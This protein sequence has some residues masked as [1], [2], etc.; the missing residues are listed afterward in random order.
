MEWYEWTAWGLA[1]TTGLYSA[2]RWAIEDRHRK[3]TRPKWEIRHFQNDAYTLTT[4][5]PY[6]AKKVTL[7]APVHFAEAVVDETF[8]PRRSAKF[9]PTLHMG[10]GTGNEFLITWRHPFWPVPQTE[11][12]LLPPKPRR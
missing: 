7:D 2:T 9:M 6:T 8:P 5:L 3:A 10:Y 12:I 4:L 1:L 11:V